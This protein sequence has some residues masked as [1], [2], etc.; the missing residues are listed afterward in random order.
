[1]VEV[2][3]HVEVTRP[4]FKQWQPAANAMDGWLLAMFVFCLLTARVIYCATGE[5]GFQT[6]MQSGMPKVI[7]MALQA[8][9]SILAIWAGPKI[10][11]QFDS[12]VLGYAAGGAIFLALSVLLLWL[13]IVQG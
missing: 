1:M 9:V 2:N 4:I 5:M 12:E 11:R 3:G 6:C 13:G 7:G 8:G 10:G